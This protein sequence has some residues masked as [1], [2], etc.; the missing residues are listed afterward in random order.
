MNFN[1]HVFLNELQSECLRVQDDDFYSKNIKEIILNI[2]AEVFLLQVKK[3]KLGTIKR[4]L[5]LIK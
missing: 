2:G 5:R 3:E 4:S 1:D